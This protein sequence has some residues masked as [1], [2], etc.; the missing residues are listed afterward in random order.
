[1]KALVTRPGGPPGPECSA[2]S[3][4][5][6]PTQ[7]HEGTAQAAPVVARTGNSHR[8]ASRSRALARARY[9]VHGD[10][11]GEGAKTPTRPPPDCDTP[12]Y[13]VKGGCD[14]GAT[15]TC[16][17][18]WLAYAKPPLAPSLRRIGR[19]QSV[20]W[21]RGG[22]PGPH[23]EAE[24]CPSRM[25]PSGRSSSSGSMVR[26]AEFGPGWPA[27]RSSG[28]LMSAWLRQPTDMNSQRSGRDLR[29]FWR[30]W[31][32]AAEG[33]QISVGYRRV[34]REWGREEGGCQSSGGER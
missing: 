27:S 5:R 12:R 4:L 17:S 20:R 25:P 8:G 7:N 3:R 9:V 29:R 28:S 11:I 1:M 23:P 22:A 26:T 6:L 10:M 2:D 13:G 14:R 24:G 21:G 15:S 30:L 19:Q 32:I 31:L 33:G 16:Q 34:P 18:A